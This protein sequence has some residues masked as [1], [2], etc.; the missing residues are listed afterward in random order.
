M[1]SAY[2]HRGV[3]VTGFRYLNDLHLTRQ[4]SAVKARRGRDA[5]YVVAKNFEAEV[6]LESEGGEPYPICVPA[7]FRTDLA[8]VPPLARGYIGRVGP[9]LEASVIHDWLYVAW[10]EEKRRPTEQ[11]RRFADDVFLFAM[12]EAKVGQLTRSVIYKAVAWFGWKAF[13]C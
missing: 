5:N 4:I 11:M 9:H 2:P 3:R 6:Q 1:A 8:S 10:R 12:A 13:Y 7:D